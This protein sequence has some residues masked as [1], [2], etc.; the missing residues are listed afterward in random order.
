MGLNKLL[1]RVFMTIESIP[2]NLML[3]AS[4]HWTSQIS[5]EAVASLLSKQS[6]CAVL[7][8]FLPIPVKYNG[9]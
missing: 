9:P 1:M 7:I 8:S 4:P 2:S 3:L 5:Y 6:V